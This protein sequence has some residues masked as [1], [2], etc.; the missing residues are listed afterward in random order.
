MDQRQRQIAVVIKRLILQ[1]EEQGTVWDELSTLT[2]EEDIIF[3]HPRLMRSMHFGD[4]D[5]EFCV[6][7][8]IKELIESSAGN[9]DTITDHL[10]L[11][12]WLKEN[13]PLNYAKLFGHSQLLLDELH[14]R[15]INSSFEVNQYILRIRDCIESDPELA[16]GTMKELLESLMKS[17]LVARGQCL[18]GKEEM[19]NLLKKTQQTL[20]LDPS[21]FDSSS[22]GGELVKRTLSNLGQVVD[23]IVKMRNQYG[24]GHGRSRQSGVTPRHARLVV[25]SGAALA[26]FLVETF[27]YHQTFG[28]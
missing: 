13:D 10:R 2:G 9:L 25:N 22:R 16:I 7:E 21:D 8:V 4:D 17:I 5:Y 23:G 1:S 14:I 27:E 3:S 11:P 20:K 18:T 24:T 19:Q 15:T 26:V 28:N 12:Q 6:S